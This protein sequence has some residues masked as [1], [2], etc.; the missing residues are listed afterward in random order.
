MSSKTSSD[1]TAAYRWMVTSRV[2]AGFI[3]G[4][5][6]ASLVTIVLTL[7]FK[8][9]WKT[10]QAEALL[11]ATLWSFVIYGVIIIWVFTTRTATR[12]WLG[13]GATGVFLALAW[14]LLRLT[15][16]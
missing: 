10:S 2:V 13:V 14:W 8:M 9:L 15:A 16:N 12:A 5:L 6:L 4:Y 11:T 7:L 3:G 1:S